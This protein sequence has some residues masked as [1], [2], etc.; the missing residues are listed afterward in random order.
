MLCSIGIS[1][2]SKVSYLVL[3]CL[4]FS[5]P[6]R[7][8]NAQ[9]QS[10]SILKTS[11]PH[12]DVRIEYHVHRKDTSIRHGQFKYFFRG[13]LIVEGK[14]HAGKKHGKWKRRYPAGNTFVEA[15]YLF[16]KAH[17][18][19]KY[20]HPN[21]KTKAQI[22]FDRGVRTGQW[23]GNYDEGQISGLWTYVDDTLK[24]RQQTF[25]HP[26][27][28]E[29][30][31]A[32]PCLLEEYYISESFP[33]FTGSWKKYYN[34][35]R[36]FCEERFRKGERDSIS[37]QYYKSGI[38]WKK[39]RYDKGA[40]ISIYDWNYPVSRDAYR[41]TFRGGD[42]FLNFY[43]YQGH[44]NF[45]MDYLNGKRHGGFQLWHDEVLKLQGEYDNGLKTGKWQLFEAAGT[46]NELISEVFFFTDDSAM[47]TTYLDEGKARV[48]FILND[49]M[50][51]GVEREYDQYDELIRE[52]K[53]TLNN[54]NGLET[55]YR[56]TQLESQGNYSWGLKTG[57]W[58]YYNDFGKVIHKETYAN[59]IW[60]DEV[61]LA[62]I[63]N[64]GDGFYEDNFYNESF[65]FFQKRKF[66]VATNPMLVTAEHFLNETSSTFGSD[67]L[68]N[69]LSVNSEFS[70]GLN[71]SFPH[72]VPIDASEKRVDV[73]SDWD[74][75]LI[76]E[77][78]DPKKPR[79]KRDPID[80]K[81]GIVI[82]EL[83][84]DEFGFVESSELVRGIDPEW[85]QKI[86]LLFSVY[87]FWEPG[88]LFHIPQRMTVFVKV[89]IEYRLV[90]G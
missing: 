89:P 77:T 81:V 84:I 85:D 46:N 9:V 80:P 57:D 48:E 26:N 38:L 73:V 24:G 21:G 59:E 7:V 42:G 45:K 76:I 10:A 33:K 66:L 14:Y 70:P 68:E 18:Q 23:I 5:A 19:W 82:V 20:Y 64:F 12:D 61:R 52:S 65:D 67:Q 2:T 51:Q 16:G 41:G 8:L 25:Y 86:D 50:K 87:A 56:R 69:L 37:I 39:S 83:E 63:R 31:T 44:K 53:Y 36:L 11:K 34:N 60:V 88:F 4:I 54:K 90:K 28:T 72:L 55:Q 49:G 71:A 79:I 74:I 47:F 22:F 29:R 58:V 27:A 43:D 3:A 62:G 13:A 30:G 1:T 32:L 40:L 75:G 35:G 78:L 17:G 15:N 6:C